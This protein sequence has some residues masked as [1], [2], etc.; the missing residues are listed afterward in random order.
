MEQKNKKMG[1][2]QYVRK[3]LETKQVQHDLK[4]P[5]GKKQLNVS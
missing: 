1:L 3:F 2:W 4:R 5:K